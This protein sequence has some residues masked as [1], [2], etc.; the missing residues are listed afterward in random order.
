MRVNFITLDMT[1]AKS[2]D[3]FKDTIKHYGVIKGSDDLE[4]D[5]YEWKKEKDFAWCANFLGEV[6][7]HSYI[8]AFYENH[9]FFNCTL[10]R[11]SELVKSSDPDAMI[12]ACLP[13]KVV[14]QW[15]ERIFSNYKRRQKKKEL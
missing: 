5:S 3:R 15:F 10:L 9:P 6:D 2:Q 11:Y 13:C 12:D 14:E 4:D 1:E 7:Q 8:I